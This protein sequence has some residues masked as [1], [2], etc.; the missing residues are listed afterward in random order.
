M[1]QKKFNIIAIA[2]RFIKRMSWPARIGA[3]ILLMAIFTFAAVEV[4]GQ[5]WFCNSCHVMN[6]YYDSWQA[7]SHREIDCLKCH[8]EP[9]AINYA[10]AKI[11]GL[12]QTV[13]CLVG[14]VGTKANGYVPDASCLRSGCHENQALVQKQLQFASV[15]FTHAGHVDQTVN[16][17]KI[18]CTT[19]HNHFEGD[20][21]FSVDANVCF[22]CHFLKQ[23][24]TG[25]RI[26]QTDCRSCHEVP[27]K[28]IKRGM[29]EVNH[30][31]FVSY[32][33]NCDDSCHKGQIE[34][35]S[36]VDENTCLM[37]HNF[38]A[39][40]RPTDSVQLHELHGGS[41]RKVECFA[42]HGK[43]PHARTEGDSVAAMMQCTNCHSDTHAVQSGIYAA[44]SHPQGGDENR[45]LGPMY[46]THVAC[47]DC[48]V[49]PKP[50]AARGIQSI[51]KV[52]RATAEACDKCHEPGTGAKFIPFWQGQIKKLHAQV[53]SKLGSLQ[54]RFELQPDGADK[55][56][57]AARIAEARMLL[58]TV[59]ADGSWGVHNLKYTEA[60]LMKANEIINDAR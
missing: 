59:Q 13:D 24:S 35:E 11:N 26:V 43:I 40:R 4:T 58:D 36:R 19:C 1:A 57:L 50:V 52:A 46:L 14:R 18:E 54:T 45:V 60:L 20:E 21:H 6:E 30:A 29:V 34:L 8:T 33:V 44:G 5:P 7:S 9:G 17:V 53:Q 16:G 12:A 39:S 41:H 55:D 38:T 10:R 48:H 3:L 27:D 42:C 47:A 25:K 28:V 32:R 51:G 56:Q 2:W 15:K 37:C 49:E 31:E 22:T 23:P